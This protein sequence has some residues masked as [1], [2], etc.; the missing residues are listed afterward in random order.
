LL[1]VPITQ[2]RFPSKNSYHLRSRYALRLQSHS[3][4]LVTVVGEEICWGPNKF[5]RLS[6]EVDLRPR[7]ADIGNRT[8]YSPVR[9]LEDI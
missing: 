8:V 6:I 9:S 5:P 7:N 1:L 2:I 4:R 3:C